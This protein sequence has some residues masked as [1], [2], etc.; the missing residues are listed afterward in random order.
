[1]LHSLFYYYC[2]KIHGGKQLKEGRISFGLWLGYYSAPGREGAPRECEAAAQTEPQSKVEM[3]AGVLLI[4]S[5]T[6][7][8]RTALP[9]LGSVSHLSLPNG[10]APLQTCAEVYLLGNHGP[11]QDDSTAYLCSI[12]LQG[13]TV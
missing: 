10:V 8:N 9:N 7:T 5:G 2:D 6:P 11:C 1:M 3:D 4:R 12:L 13:C